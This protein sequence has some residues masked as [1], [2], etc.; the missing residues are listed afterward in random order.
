MTTT[1]SNQ[2]NYKIPSF[3]PDKIVYNCQDCIFSS[4]NKSLPSNRL[5]CNSLNREVSVNGTCDNVEPH[6]L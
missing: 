4:Y 5:Y 6:K 3:D 2:A 1:L